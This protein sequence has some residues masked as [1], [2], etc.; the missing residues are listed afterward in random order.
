MTRRLRHAVPASDAVAVDSSVLSGSQVLA[1]TA[2]RRVD[3]FTPR[4]ETGSAEPSS[5][6]AFSRRVADSALSAVD[7]YVGA[8]LRVGVASGARGPSEGLSAPVLGLGDRLEVPRVA[9]QDPAAQVVE[10]ETLWDRAVVVLPDNAVDSEPSSPSAP[11]VDLAV[12]RGTD[13]A[14]PDP[15]V[16]VGNHLVHDTFDDGRSGV[17]A[18]HTNECSLTFS[19]TARHALYTA[20]KDGGYP[21]P[22]STRNRKAT[23]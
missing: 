8:L 10:D 6:F 18:R 4:R 14:R 13:G 19:V 20:C 9:A 22:L 11:L 23:P 5:S 12:A 15:A 3:R 2:M 1:L 16:S 17:D 21:D 7:A